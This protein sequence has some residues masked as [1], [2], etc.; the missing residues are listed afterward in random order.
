M[1]AFRILAL[2]L[3]S[4]CFFACIKQ[5]HR[6]DGNHDSLPAASPERQYNLPVAVIYRSADGGTS[7][8]P[9]DSGIPKD[10]TVSS[11]LVLQDRIFA[12]TDLHGIYLIRGGETEWKRIDEDLSENIDINTIAATGNSL[13]IGSWRQGI[14]LSKNGGKSWSTPAVQINGTAIRCLHATGDLLL[15]GTD[16][17]IY[18]SMDQGNTWKHIY[19]GAQ[20]NGFTQKNNK[21]YAALMNGAIMTIDN[22]ENWEYIYQPHTL[23][24]ISAD[25]KSIYAMA[26][27]DGLKKSDDDGVTW[28]RINNGLGALNF[29]TFEVKRFNNKLFAAQWHGIYMSD[30]FG[31]NWHLIENGLPDSTAFTTLETTRTGLIAGIGLRKEKR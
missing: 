18:R 15:A 11:F 17:G 12:T 4:L 14:M 10:A 6:Q 16:N 26:L 28:E 31:K 29:Y 19:K 8:M 22:G 21:V 1:P 27:G 30:D 3:L 7:W 5:N 23:H 24:D 13:V 2:L 25:D 20:V 9:Y